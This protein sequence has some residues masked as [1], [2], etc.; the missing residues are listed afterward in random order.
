MGLAVNSQQSFILMQAA[1][2]LSSQLIGPIPHINLT[3][4]LMVRQP[5]SEAVQSDGEERLHP[6]PF[7]KRARDWEWVKNSQ[8]ERRTEESK[9]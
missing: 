7:W 8:S 9:K 2:S 4:P 3:R 1:F 5:Y 6:L